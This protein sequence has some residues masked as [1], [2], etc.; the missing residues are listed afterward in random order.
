V[1][2]KAPTSA[3]SVGALRLRLVAVR[4][5]PAGAMNLRGPDGKYAPGVVLD[6]DYWALLPRR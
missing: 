6:F 4:N 3:P 5:A 2:D 1:L